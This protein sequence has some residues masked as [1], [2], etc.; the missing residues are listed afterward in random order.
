MLYF[1]RSIDSRDAIPYSESSIISFIFSMLAFI[2]GTVIFL[3]THSLIVR[4]GDVGYRI[5]V[6]EDTRAKSTLGAEVSFF[7]HQHIRENTEE[8]YGFSS[9]EEYELFEHLISVS[10]V[11]P[12][13][14]LSVLKVATVADIVSAI[15]RGDAGLLKKVSGIGTKTAMRIVLELKEIFHAYASP[16]VFDTR[17]T[18]MND[19]LIDALIRLGY[20]RT[21]AQEAVRSIPDTIE[22]M[23]EKLKYALRS[24]V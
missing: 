6:P 7:L 19:D 2:H 9:Q 3:D 1:W 8:L 4:T 24:I 18:L 23:E 17:H 10:G 13:S 21:Q 14:A 16:Q 12:K 20:S 5:F 15:G 22:V 11:G